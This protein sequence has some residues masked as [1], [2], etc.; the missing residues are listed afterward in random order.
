LID[1]NGN[2]GTS[3]SPDRGDGISNPNATV[4]VPATGSGSATLPILLDL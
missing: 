1:R 4:T 2:L 3:L